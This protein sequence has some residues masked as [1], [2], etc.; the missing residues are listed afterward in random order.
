[1]G[2][3]VSSIAGNTGA[4]TL[5]GGVVNFTNQIQL[6]GNYTGFAVPNC[7]L[8]ASVAANIL[9]VALKDNAGNDPSSTSPVYNQL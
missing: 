1:M 3:G 2:A 7:T 9:T 5:P 4:F 6:D 8:A